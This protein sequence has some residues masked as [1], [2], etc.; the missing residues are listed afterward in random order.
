MIQRKANKT[1]E[2]N[3]DLRNRFIYLKKMALI[4]MSLH[5]SGLDGLYTK[6]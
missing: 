6:Y 2:Q 1:E 4:E 5:S 3:K